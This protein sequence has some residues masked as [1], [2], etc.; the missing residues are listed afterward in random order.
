MGKQI[1]VKGCKVAYSGDIIG[2]CAEASFIDL[3]HHRLDEK[4]KIRIC[5]KNKS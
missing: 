4:Y 3:T 5:T 2:R 1:A